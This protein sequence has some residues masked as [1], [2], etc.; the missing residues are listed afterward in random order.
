MTLSPSDKTRYQTLK[1]ILVN[2]WD[3]TLK[4]ADAA[5]QL[6]Q[7]KLYLQ[8]FDTWEQF[9][10]EVLHFTP[11]HVNRLIS[12]YS[13]EESIQNS[14]ERA[15][16]SEPMGS[17]SLGTTNIGL[18]NERQARELAKVPEKDRP[19][20]LAQAAAAGPV[21]AKA[22]AATAEKSPPAPVIRKDAIGRI[23]PDGIL[24]DWDRALEM[25]KHLR[26]LASE[27]KCTVENGLADRDIIFAEIMNPTIGEAAALHY[28][29]SQIAPHSVCPTCQG[30]ARNNCQ[31]CR[32][33]GWIS[34]YCY[35]SA[36]T[37]EQRTFLAFSRSRRISRWSL[38]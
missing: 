4:A 18:T 6:K 38:F 35:D 1:K 36:I 3:S 10:T 17:L 23:I 9:C 28:T 21:T 29:L 25:A 20:V 16:P 13:V 30:K 24:A 7:D 33:R 37:K 32:R 15:K 34:K 14:N 5:R 11:Q 26:A 27:I 31:L 22:I 12:A 8:E 2:N 19:A